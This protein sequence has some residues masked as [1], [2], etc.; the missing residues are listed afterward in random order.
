MTTTYSLT[1]HPGYACWAS[2]TPVGD[3]THVR[4]STEIYGE[5]VKFKTI[6]KTFDLFLYPDELN[7]LI[8]CL[9]E[10]LTHHTQGESNE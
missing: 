8:I 4:F 2:A 7:K 9:Q 6:E 3:Y 10:A 5:D 1:L